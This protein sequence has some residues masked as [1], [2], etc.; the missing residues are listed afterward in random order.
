MHRRSSTACS[1]ASLHDEYYQADLAR[2][3]TLAAE[4]TTFYEQLLQHNEDSELR[5][6]AAVANNDLARIWNL[7]GNSEKAIAACR[8]GIDLLSPLIAAYPAD[9]KYLDTRGTSF[10]T[11][12]DAE[13]RSRRTFMAEE[14]LRQAAA[15]YQLLVDRF[16]NEPGYQTGLAYAL[17]DI[18]MLCWSSRRLDQAEEYYGRADKLLEKLPATGPDSSYASRVLSN[19]GALLMNRALVAGD[20]GNPGRAKEL[21]EQAIALQQQVLHDSP[22]DPVASDFLFKHYSNLGDTCISAGQPA[23]AASTAEMLIDAFPKRLDAYQQAASLLLE[24]ATLADHAD[25]HAGTDAE[26]EFWNSQD[27]DTDAD[28]PAAPERPATADD[29]RRRADSLFFD[30]LSVSD[31]NPDSTV[32][33]ARFLLL[34]KDKRFRDPPHALEL[35]QR[36]VTDYPERSRAWFT[37][38]LAHYRAGNWQAADAA[39]QNSIKFSRGESPNAY[40]WLLLS[41]IRFQQ[42]HKVEA[43]QLQ[44]KAEHWIA[45]NKTKDQDLLRLAAEAEALVPL[46]KESNA[47]S[48]P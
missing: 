3:E 28:V 10:L 7:V 47:V 41:M 22:G 20:R 21:L 36:V 5:Y 13:L 9:G 23:A 25:S 32:N 37:L 48:K 31:R 8:R 15:D 34:C 39:E 27:T 26:K 4:A 29:Y 17:A 30:A 40:D 19:K 35:A 16:P 33:F 18:A 14:P 44:K 38:A 43:R 24:C 42:G 1:P 11:L 12:G 6:R 2:A 45:E 46:D